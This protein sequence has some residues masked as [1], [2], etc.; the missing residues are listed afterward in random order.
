MG[1]ILGSPILENNQ[2]CMGHGRSDDRND[3]NM[4]VV[5]V[6]ANGQGKDVLVTRR[7]RTW[8]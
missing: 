7:T 2:F 4:D 6:R 8:L 1:F 5:V 3:S